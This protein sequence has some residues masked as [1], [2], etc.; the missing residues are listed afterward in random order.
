[1]ANDIVRA[2][3][4]GIK[5]CLFQKLKT[6]EEKKELNCSDIE[7]LAV[8]IRDGSLGPEVEN[9]FTVEGNTISI[10]LDGT[11]LHNGSYSVEVTGKVSG[12]NIRGAERNA[13]TVVEYNEQ[14]SITFAPFENETGGVIPLTF[15]YYVSSEG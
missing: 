3:D 1:M 4:F 14:Q 10:Y 12:Y 15:C 9:T 5:I 11:K 2:N 13:F 8:S 6:D 7:D